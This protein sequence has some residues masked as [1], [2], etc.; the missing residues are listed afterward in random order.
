MSKHPCKAFLIDPYVLQ[1]EDGVLTLSTESAIRELTFNGDWR[2]ISP[3]ISPPGQT[4]DTFDVVYF[5]PDTVY[6]DDN[7]LWGASH[8]FQI[9]GMQPLAGRGLVLGTD[10][11]GDSIAPTTTLDALWRRA[12]LCVGN[13]EVRL[14]SVPVGAA[15]PSQALRMHRGQVIMDWAGDWW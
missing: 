14:S 13:V 6:V 15:V 4:V 1:V 5:D 3:L 12:R 11:E 10:D 2:T 8:F 7:G 9:D